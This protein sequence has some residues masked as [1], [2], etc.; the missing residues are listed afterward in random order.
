MKI[1]EAII[2][3]IHLYTS[4]NATFDAS[5]LPL[6]QTTMNDENNTIDP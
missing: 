1:F 2:A 5:M 4:H 6:Y 3:Y